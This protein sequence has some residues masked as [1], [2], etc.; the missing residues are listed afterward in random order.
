MTELLSTTET[1]GSIRLCLVGLITREGFHPRALWQWQI[2][3]YS[4]ASTLKIF[5]V[6]Q[7]VS[8]SRISVIHE[9]L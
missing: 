1:P 9:L 3:G 5:E 2:A 7:L 6:I 8:T 4:F